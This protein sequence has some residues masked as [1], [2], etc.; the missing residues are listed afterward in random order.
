MNVT[1]VKFSGVFSGIPQSYVLP[2]QSGATVYGAIETFDDSGYGSRRWFSEEAHRAD[3]EYTVKGGYRPFNIVV[4]GWFG[5]V[6]TTLGSTIT[7]MNSLN[8]GVFTNTSGKLTLYRNNSSGKSYRAFREQDIKF[9]NPDGAG[10]T[11]FV[12]T[13]RNKDGK[14]A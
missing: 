2:A 11:K 9:D 8:S 10:I 7:Y 4:G 3:G 5:N 12:I 13:F 14:K 1:K 6:N